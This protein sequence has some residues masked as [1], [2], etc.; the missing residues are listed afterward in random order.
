V[1]RLMRREGGRSGW[2]CETGR[3]RGRGSGDVSWVGKREE[4]LIVFY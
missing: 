4:D 1:E 2:R 3:E